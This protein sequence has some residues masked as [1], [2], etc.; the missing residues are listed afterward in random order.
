[1]PSLTASS[2]VNNPVAKHKHY[3]SYLIFKIPSLRVIDYRRVKHTVRQWIAV[4]LS[5]W[6]LSLS[7]LSLRLFKVKHSDS[8]IPTP[9]PH[10]HRQERDTAVAMF[11]GKAGETL[12]KEIVKTS[13]HK[14]V[15][16]HLD[17]T[18]CHVDVGLPSPTQPR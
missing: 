12:A 15:S 8:L 3:R 10:S 13:E 17:V 2:L 14:Y 11:G 16:M 7:Q 4:P 6:T 5:G 18:V 9:Y 1:M